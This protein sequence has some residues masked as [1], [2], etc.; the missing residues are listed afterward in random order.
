[1][2]F[3]V[4]KLSMAKKQPDTKLLKVYRVIDANLNRA[5]E[6]LR[7]VEEVI[8]MVLDQ[9]GLTKD[10]KKLRHDLQRIVTS[11]PDQELL[12]KAREAEADV[13]RAISTKAEKSRQEIKDIF[14]ANMKRVQESLRVLEEF[15]KVLGNGYSEQFKQIRFK[16]YEVEKKLS[17]KLFS[18]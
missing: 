14:A 15:S 12:L 4:L 8:R 7:V 1:M 16:I 5:R 2:P 13:G 17:F 9:K 10:F 3:F 11:L 18:R 6:G